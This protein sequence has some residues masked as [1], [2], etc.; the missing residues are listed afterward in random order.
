MIKS[1]SKSLGEEGVSL[2]F[3]DS[4]SLSNLSSAIVSLLITLLTTL[5][6]FC[7]SDLFNSD[8]VVCKSGNV[9]NISSGI[10]GGTTPLK[11]FSASLGIFKGTPGLLVNN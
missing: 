4:N 8:C 7:F 11:P 2:C 6:A 9:L 1:L 3:K 5:V 10:V